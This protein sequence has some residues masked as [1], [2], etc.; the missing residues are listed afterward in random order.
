MCLCV[1]VLVWVYRV[2]KDTSIEQQK[3]MVC[4]L[5]LER[6]GEWVGGGDC[7]GYVALLD[8]LFVCVCQSVQKVDGEEEGYEGRMLSGRCV[9]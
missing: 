4:A 3:E 7:E 5:S 9:K 8:C 2:I 1:F 6:E